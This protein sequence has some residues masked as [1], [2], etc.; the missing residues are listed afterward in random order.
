MT[1]TVTA[2]EVFVEFRWLSAD[3]W[4]LSIPVYLYLAVVAGGAYLTGASAWF[5]RR[6][7][8]SD[9]N[10][11]E[12][13]ILRWG[14]L[15][16]VLSAGGA[17]LAVLSHL[18]VYYRAILFPVY[19]TNYDSWITIGTWILVML[20]VLAIV[21][22]VLQL[23]G[24][25]AAEGDGASRWPRWF[26]AKL[27]LLDVVDRFV[28]RIRPPTAGLALL[29]VV[30]SLFA[31]ATIYTGFEL[32][33]VETVPLWNQPVLVPLL[34]LTSGVAAGI[35]STLA[36]TMV[37]EREIT[38]MFGGYA[39]VGG[40]LSGV[41]LLIAGYGWTQLAANNTP[42]AAA[43]YSS[44]TDGLLAF[45][46]WVV[47]LGFALA[48]LAGVFLGLAA[49]TGR[50]TASVERIGGPVLIGSFGLLFVSS[51]LLR[52]LLLLAAEQDPVVVV[53]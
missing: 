12:T 43:S 49:A 1:F 52:V 37:F 50:L 9:S 19:L 23:F 4:D 32:A 16:S 3:Y 36:V 25:A 8:G 53:V 2:L 42:A 39:A 13:E 18:A 30:G 26:V 27:G 10:G 35:G 21:C 24:E 20:S 48:L 6:W 14:F 29:H 5:L 45:G 46:V 28:D 31:L 33:I 41:S 15:V 17:G 44:L 34:F 51:L 38:P 40:V 11:L 7:R 47:A 22:L